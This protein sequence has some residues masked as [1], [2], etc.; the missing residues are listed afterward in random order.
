MQN[1]ATRLNQGKLRVGLVTP[2]YIEMTAEALTMGANKYG[3]RN[4]MKGLTVSSILDSLNRHLL[5][6]EKGIDNDPESGLSHLSHIG[7]N[8]MFLMHFT[9]DP[10]WDDRVKE[11]PKDS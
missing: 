2:Q 11:K 3:E 5:E 8:L 9:N 7:A 6:Y 4:W 10:K 1:E